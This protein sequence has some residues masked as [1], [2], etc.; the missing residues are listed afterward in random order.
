MREVILVPTYK[1]PEHLFCCLKRIRQIEPEI[2][3]CV[4]PD[5][6][7]ANDEDTEIAMRHHRNK[8]TQ[9]FAVP[10]HDYH[11]NSYNALEALRWA[12]NEGFDRVFYV[13]DDVM[14]HPDFFA[15]HR[16]QH[17]MWPRIFATMAW[18]F[19][20]H[21]PITEDVMFQPWYYAIGTCFARKKL[22]LV[23][24][25]AN[26]KY[27]ADMVG[28]VERVFPGSQLNTPFGIQHYEQDGLIQRVLDVDKTQTISPG[29]TKCSHIGSFGYNRGWDGRDELFSNCG[30]F[31]DRCQ[32][33][34][35]FIADPYWRAEVFGREIVE[36]EIGHELPKR[37]FTYRITVPG[38]WETTYRS[39]LSKQ[40]LPR[41]IH[42]VLLPANA[43][44]EKTS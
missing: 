27:Y 26:P 10:D 16:G 13:E 8:N 12:Y 1:R 15:W 21:A 38:G 34:E 39:E 25:H 33:L 31:A 18:I 6:C 14:V 17:E 4:F 37:E 28:Y 30:D 11:G 20:R 22:E 43:V 19:N 32:R 5:H 2:Q 9:V 42:S 7:T 29:I 44:I 36:R 41:R 23:V 3:V 35:A 40:R 24:Q